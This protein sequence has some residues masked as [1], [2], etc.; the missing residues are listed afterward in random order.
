MEDGD[1]TVD[2]I[3]ASLDKFRLASQ[4]SPVVAQFVDL[5]GHCYSICLKE[6]SLGRAP[7]LS[8]VDAVSGASRHLG[9]NPDPWSWKCQEE[10]TFANVPPQVL[11]LTVLQS[12]LDYHRDQLEVQ[13]NVLQSGLMDISELL[14]KQ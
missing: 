5:V 11:V 13:N 3:L 8:L 12:A 2:L 10:Q 14:A 4:Q 9:L 6:F 7:W 1:A